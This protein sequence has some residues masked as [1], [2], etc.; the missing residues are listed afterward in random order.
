MKIWKIILIGIF[1][2]FGVYAQ[3]QTELDRVLTPDSIQR[4]YLQEPDRAL[5][6]LDMAE[7]HDLPG[8]QPF[9]INFLRAMAYD[10]KHQFSQES[11]YIR[12]ALQDDSVQLV[13][14]R[15]LRAMSILL[16]ALRALN[17]YEEGIDVCREAVK[18]ARSLG[19]VKGEGRILITMGSLYFR[20]NRP[21][22]AEA[23]YQESIELMEDSK[24]VT[25]LAELSW[26]YGQMINL[27]NSRKMY[28]KSIEICRWRE[29]LI[30][31]MSTMPGPPLGYIDQQYGYL[32]SKMAFILQIDGKEEEAAEAYRRFLKTEFSTYPYGRGEII[33]Y[34]LAAHRYAEA[35]KLNKEDDQPMSDSIT[36]QYWIVL[37]RYAQAYRGLGDYRRADAYQQRCSHLSDSIYA[38]EKESQA[39]EYAAMFDLNEKEL[40][41]SKA[42][43]EVRQNR[44]ISVSACLVAGLSFVLIWILWRNLKKT[45]ERNRIAVR[46][47]DEL[48]AQ[49]EELRRSYFVSQ[50]EDHDD[51]SSIG[52]G[53]SGEGT[54]EDGVR[55][56]YAAFMR[57]EQKIIQERLFL[58]PKFGREDLLRL[59]NISKNDLVAFLQKH[60]NVDNV[61]D[62]VNHLRAEYAVKLMKEKPLLSI[63]AIAEESGFS[64]R[65]TFYRAFYKVFGMTPTQ[66]LKANDASATDDKGDA[67]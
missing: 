2:I 6:L 53:Q 29:K 22:Q 58:Q 14:E 23:Y 30:Q 50:L 44:I 35:L 38:K 37:D 45:R 43:A 41:I 51:A 31:R 33:P 18:L 1:S 47:I 9:E 49:R 46:Q 11:Y 26:G 7:K 5:Q 19:N 3:G 32:Y 65:S 13:P 64:S 8:L 36:Y 66:Y 67:L 55:T 21:E 42:G 12:L 62:Y 24:D 34:L 61:S 17:R 4:I 15:K 28:E 52:K 39:Q 27:Y 63:E 10:V 40:Q 59:T 56:N 57:M 20:M 25:V 54:D 60:G 16:D 48:V